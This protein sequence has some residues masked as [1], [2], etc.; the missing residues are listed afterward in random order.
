MT[1]EFLLLVERSKIRTHGI[2]MMMKFHENPFCINDPL[3]EEVVS[4][5]LDP[6]KTEHVRTVSF[7]A[8][9]QHFMAYLQSKVQNME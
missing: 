6:K 7:L 5:T 3:F 1:F 9:N 2:T 8:Q 4:W